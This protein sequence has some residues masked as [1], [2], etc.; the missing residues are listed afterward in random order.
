MRITQN[1][2]NNN[3][4]CFCCL[5]MIYVYTIYPVIRLNSSFDMYRFGTKS[6]AYHF[7]TDKVISNMILTQLNTC[8]RV[9]STSHLFTERNTTI[10]LQ[11]RSSN[12]N[13][14]TTTITKVT[15]QQQQQQQHTKIHRIDTLY[16]HKLL[17]GFMFFLS[18]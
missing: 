14:I 1:V 15:E 17:L 9:L 12:S 7:K 18:Q 6:S 3:E 16:R 13:S 5:M 2:S 4:P 11:N 8:H 10:T